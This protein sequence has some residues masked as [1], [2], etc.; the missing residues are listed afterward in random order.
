[1][2]DLLLDSA[3]GQAR[4]PEPL[5]EKKG[6]HDGNDGEQRPHDDEEAIAQREVENGVD[7]ATRTSSQP[8]LEAR[9][10][11]VMFGCVRIL[12]RWGGRDIDWQV[13]ILI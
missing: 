7:H 10:R 11:L 5:Q 3:G 9:Y 2:R 1:M 4:L 6:R 12:A 13:Q 8:A